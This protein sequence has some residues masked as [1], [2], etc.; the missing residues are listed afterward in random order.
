MNFYSLITSVFL[1][2]FG[3]GYI[4]FFGVG[5]IA[6]HLY[7]PQD[8]SWILLLVQSLLTLGPTLI[9]FLAG[10]ISS[11]FPKRKIMFLGAGLTAV[12]LYFGHLTSFVG[13]IWVYVFLTGTLCGFYNS[14]KMSAIPLQA[15]DLEKSTTAVNGLMTII[16]TVAML[17]GVPLGTWLYENHPLAGLYIIV[18]IFSLGAFSALKCSYPQEELMPLSQAFQ[19]LIR[20]TTDLLKVFWPLL[21][22]GPLLW[23]VAAA[24]SLSITAFA[25][26]R[27]LGSATLCSLMSLWAAVGI[28]AG[29]V[30]SAVPALQKNRFRVSF[31][32]SVV[33]LLLIYFYPTIVL[34]MEPG[35]VVDDNF[36][37]YCVAASLFVLIGLIFGVTTNLVD[38]AY[39]EAV[40]LAK[41]EGHGAALQS[42]LVS[43]FSFVVSGGVGYLTFKQ[44]M[45][46]ID[47]FTML[48]VLSAMASVPIF[49][50]SRRQ[51]ALH[52]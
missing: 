37:I 39:L 38:S 26:A 52:H 15:V 32:G 5:Y 33:L 36:K 35:T 10:P 11:A 40:A 24:V 46:P 45:S 23:G 25:E 21:L 50:Y 4:K 22:S 43:L 17:M 49:L 48:A 34:A 51:N 3:L 16:F 6:H 19:D 8:K 42:G 27:F 2:S 20:N 30:L 44:L 47:Q 29:N 9:Y 1:V 7:T 31:G 18:G 41:L 13:T 12:V 28:I 14:S